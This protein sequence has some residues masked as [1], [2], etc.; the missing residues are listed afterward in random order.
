[1]DMRVVLDL[2]DA[3]VPDR[4]HA[5]VAADRVVAARLERPVVGRVGLELGRAEVDDDLVAY[6]HAALE[7]DARKVLEPLGEDA[8]HAVSVCS[9]SQPLVD[10]EPLD[11][12]I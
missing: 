8:E 2:D 6:A 3:A 12:G 11:V 4:D 1:M 10:T 5:R 9:L 7:R